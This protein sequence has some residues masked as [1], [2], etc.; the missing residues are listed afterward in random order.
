MNQ[1]KHMENN[2]DFR[3]HSI[4]SFS[5]DEIQNWFES[6]MVEVA[7]TIGVSTQDL[8]DLVLTQY[9]EVDERAK[10][11][12][13]DINTP[14]RQALRDKI[15][16]DYFDCFKSSEKS[17][18]AVIVLGQIASGKSSFYKTLV[19]GNNAF[20][21]DSDYI[22]QGYKGMEGLSRD[23]D[24]GK[25]TTQVHEEASML[26][27]KI[28]SLASKEG[29][30]LVIPKTGVSYGSIESIAK[31]LK[32]NGYYTILSY[33]DLPIKKCIERNIYRYMEELLT[34]KPSR[35]VPLE[36][37]IFID[38]KPFKTFIKFL[39]E[40]ENGLIDEFYAYSNDVL[41]NSPMKSIDIEKIKEVTIS[42]K[43]KS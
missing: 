12:T 32:Q 14:E 15:I 41:P 18:V 25:G 20:V 8:Q 5:R 30:N 31:G 10:H 29:Y 11:P 21:V 13:I 2:V 40:R 1:G 7:N 27:K 9:A 6:A 26:S 28:I 42:T 37:I 19:N 34:G 35:L 36:D 22:K 23:F 39:N 16:S 17:K 43:Q 3:L 24:D 33:V 38:D 4:S